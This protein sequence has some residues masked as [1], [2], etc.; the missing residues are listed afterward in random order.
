MIERR[1]GIITTLFLL[2]V[3]TGTWQP[4]VA[5]SGIKVPTPTPFQET[6]VSP[7]LEKEPPSCEEDFGEVVIFH[8][9]E[10]EKLAGELNKYGNCGYRIGN[11]LKGH[12]GGEETVMQLTFYGF[13]EQ[14]KAAKYEYAWFVARGPGEA[15]T[16]ANK[17]A[18]K[19]FYLKKVQPFI[20]GACSERAQKIEKESNDSDD[21]LSKFSKFGLGRKGAFF[22][23]ERKAGEAKKNEY[24]VLDAFTI[25]TRMRENKPKFDEFVAKGFRPVALWW[26]GFSSYHFVIMEKDEAIKPEGEYIFVSKQLGTDKKL[27]QL[28]KA[29]YTLALTGS[30]F[31]ILNRV[32]HKPLE[33]EYE[34]FPYYGNF[35]KQLPKFQAR[36][37]VDVIATTT[38][39]SCDAIEGEWFFISPSKKSKNKSQTENLKFLSL[40][41]FTDEYAK[42]KGWDLKRKTDLIE[43]HK[44]ELQTGFND[45]VY[46]TLKEGYK[47]KTFGLIDG[48]T[49]MFER[50]KQ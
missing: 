16:L 34:S 33:I 46:E 40:Y 22:L 43:A 38:F 44:K 48:P 7:E 47:I 41:D 6:V 1:I 31:A 5:Q 3:Y 2:F 12:L 39:T 8:G 19:G 13:F 23:F 18:E 35:K 10:L 24:R 42:Q 37:I 17:L 50:R 26:L 20:E 45:K 25:R 36:G 21:I 4:A 14:D 28:A 15:Q 29:G 9:I 49:V 11:I 30:D 27:T 32:D